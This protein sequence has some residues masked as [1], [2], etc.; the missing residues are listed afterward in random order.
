MQDKVGETLTGI[1]NSIHSFGIFVAFEA[2]SGGKRVLGLMPGSIIRG[3]P[4]NF[5]SMLG[6]EVEAAIESV[7]APEK[8]GQN[9]RMAIRV[10][11]IE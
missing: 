6:K 4:Q 2:P 8:E 10:P 1:V 9:W 11:D 3:R 5:A 7:T